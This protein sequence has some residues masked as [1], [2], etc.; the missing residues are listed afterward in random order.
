MS[1]QAPAAVVILTHFYDDFIHDFYKRLV[2]EVPEYCTV[3][4][5]INCGEKTAAYPSAEEAI[6]NHVFLCNTAMLLAL[7][8]PEKCR[9]EG[10]TGKGWTL[11]PGN[12]DL[13]MLSFVQAHPEYEHYWGIEYDV[14]YEGKWRSFFNHFASSRADLL[15]TTLYRQT[16]TSHKGL[17]PPLVAA[18]QKPVGFTEALRGFFPIFRISAQAVEAIRADYSAGWGGHYE[19]TWPTIVHNHG[20][21]IEDIGGAGDYVLPGNKNRF[22]FN[23][24]GSWSGSPGTFVF[25][26][27]FARVMK[28][29]NT[30]WHPVKPAGTYKKWQLGN[31]NPDLYETLKDSYK[32]T[33]WR[34][35]IR[36]WFLV[37]WNKLVD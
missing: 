22:Y 35:V 3:F 13:L 25:R 11:N 7:G 17:M 21:V 30:L 10:W 16:E 24:R 27:C 14:H 6:G 12:T 19:S 5:L 18:G 29:N 34:L 33:I 8:Y 4:L 20:L 32:Q 31:S 15:G 23:F 37:K 9:L 28:Y 26:P 2:A 36:A 1:E